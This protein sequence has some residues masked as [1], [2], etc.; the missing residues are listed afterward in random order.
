MHPGRFHRGLQRP[1]C[2]GKDYGSRAD[3]GDISPR[4]GPETLTLS[5]PLT[6]PQPPPSPSI[7]IQTV[8]LGQSKTSHLQKCPGKLSSTTQ[9][10]TLQ[11]SG[12][13]VFSEQRYITLLLNYS[14]PAEERSGEG[15]TDRIKPS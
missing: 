7:P 15:E 4:P 6:T 2:C 1:I 3:T 14:R 9:I 8:T 12:P 5:G 13:A 10:D 11:I